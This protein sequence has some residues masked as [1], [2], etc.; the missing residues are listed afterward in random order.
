MSHASKQHFADHPS[1]LARAGAKNLIRCEARFEYNLQ[2]QRRC[3]LHSTT[4]RLQSSTHLR[5]RVRLDRVQ[6]LCRLRKEVEERL[7]L[8]LGFVEIVDIQ[9]RAVS[10]EKFPT[11]TTCNHDALPI[12]IKVASFSIDN[13]L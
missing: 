13:R 1:S 12:D 10:L 6:D 7:S 5:N 4:G 11:K 9:R 8:T 2:F 3:N